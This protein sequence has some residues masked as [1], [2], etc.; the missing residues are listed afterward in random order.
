MCSLPCRDLVL[1]SECHH[2]NLQSNYIHINIVECMK[3]IYITMRCDRVYYINGIQNLTLTYP[4][5]SC[6]LCLL[7]TASFLP[8]PVV[9]VTVSEAAH[10]VASRSRRREVNSKPSITGILKEGEIKRERHEQRSGVYLW[11]CKCTIQGYSI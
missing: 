11:Q 8:L 7:P 1:L 10:S 6:L 2:P 3:K 4:T 9:V 5:I